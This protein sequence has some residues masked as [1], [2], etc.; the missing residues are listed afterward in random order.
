[1]RVEFRFIFLFA[2]LYIYS[3]CARGQNEDCAFD[4]S[5]LNDEFL[6]RN[7]DVAAYNW[8]DDTKIATV[9]M[10]TGEYVYI[11]K[12]ACIS[13]GMEAK[14]VIVLPPSG[15]E[16]STF[17]VNALVKFGRQFLSDVDS[18]LLESIVTDTHWPE[19]DELPEHASFEK[20]I[21]HSSYPEFYVRLERNSNIVIMTISYYMN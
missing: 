4:S 6:R 12:W 15:N 11:R 8:F 20:D 21:P 14:K 10:K 2:S 3:G 1:M 18:K 5:K 13:Y 9:L 17:W 16:D 7:P 19:V